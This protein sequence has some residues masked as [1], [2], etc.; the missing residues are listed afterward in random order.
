MCIWNTTGERHG[1]RQLYPSFK[2]HT[3]K[4]YSLRYCT[5]IVYILC[6]FLKHEF[7]SPGIWL[8][9]AIRDNFHTRIFII[10]EH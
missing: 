1:G 4:L 2:P 3:H 8:S 7:K 6:Y 10:F 5:N 9:L